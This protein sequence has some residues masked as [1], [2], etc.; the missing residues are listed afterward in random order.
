VNTLTGNQAAWAALSGTLT[1]QASTA[2]LDVMVRVLDTTTPGESAGGAV[3]FDNVQVWNQTTTGMTAMPYCEL[4]FSQSP[5]QLLVSGVIGDMP[6][7]AWVAF[8]AYLT[9]WPTSSV[10]NFAIGRRAVAT[11]NA[12]TVFASSLAASGNVALDTTAYGGWRT[13]MTSTSESLN[14][15]SFTPAANPGVFELFVRTQTAQTSGNIPNITGRIIVTEAS[16]LWY[17][18]GVLE[19]WQF[20]SPFVTAFPTTY[21]PNTWA[22]CDLG[23]V[24][25][26]PTNYGAL[27]DTTQNALTLTSQYVDSSGSQAAG[28]WNWAALVPLDGGLLLGQ[29][30]N[31]SNGTVTVT[32]QWLWGYFD[33]LGPQTGQ[34]IAWSYSVET[35]PTPAPAHS[36][37]GQGFTTSGAISIN[38]A[39]DPYLSLDPTASGGASGV[40]AGVNEFTAYLTDGVGDVLPLYT[41]FQ[42]VPLYLF[43]RGS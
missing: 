34:P 38:N 24:T 30:I 43:P 17:V 27:M 8:G 22:A 35:A 16:A 14:A 9:S 5:A 7:P 33:G 19:L 42:Y 26:P 1:T 13:N 39:S 20:Y 29:L 25:L 2:Y 12:R 4:R 11:L 37:G 23:K 15:A 40:S 18:I 36:S 31:P 41:E 28:E 21:S 32:N 3:W 10:A 6:A